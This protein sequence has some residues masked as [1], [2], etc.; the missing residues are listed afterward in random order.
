MS[1]CFRFK[2]KISL[3]EYSQVNVLGSSCRFFAMA[4][5]IE[6][7]PKPLPPVKRRPET[8]QG[9]LISKYSRRIVFQPPETWFI[10]D[11]KKKLLRQNPRASFRVS[12]TPTKD[13]CCC[14]A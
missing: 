14:R 2:G 10:W 1:D 9:A 5:I 4:C 7:F 3:D 12:S 6:V 11:C 8:V 13:V